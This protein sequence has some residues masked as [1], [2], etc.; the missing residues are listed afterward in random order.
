[1]A[2]VRRFFN[3]LILRYH[4]TCKYLSE[5]VAIIENPQFEAAVVMS[6]RPYEDM[7]LTEKIHL[8]R[9]RTQS[10]HFTCKSD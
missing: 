7:K 4:Y 9:F 6:L 1:M 8:G 5:R 3:V 10:I 2:E